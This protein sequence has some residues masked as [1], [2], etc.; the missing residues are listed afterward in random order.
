MKKSKKILY[1]I[2][3]EDILTF[4]KFKLYS[5]RGIL[6]YPLL[7]IFYFKNFEENVD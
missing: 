7:K 5:L 2:K 6:W 3:K 4:K 1:K